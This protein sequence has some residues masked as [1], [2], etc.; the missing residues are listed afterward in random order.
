MAVAGSGTG[1]WDRNVVTGEITYSAGWK[2]L[3]GYGESELTN[4]IE[5]AYKRLHPDDVQT[6]G[7]QVSQIA[8]GLQS[9]GATGVVA[10]PQVTRGGCR[11]ET[12]F[13]TID[14]Q[15]ESQLKRIEEELA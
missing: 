13:G 6:L 2:A 9:V 8:A 14:Q 10:D 3:L 1:V 15:F 4:R 5:D 12:R 11:V 7:D